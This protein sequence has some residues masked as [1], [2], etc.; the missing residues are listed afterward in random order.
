M[1]PLKQGGNEEDGKY[2]EQQ[3]DTL[4]AMYPGHAL[5][6][7]EEE[8]SIRCL[9]GLILH[10][11]PN[12]S[13]QIGFGFLPDPDVVYQR[14]NRRLDCLDVDTLRIPSGEHK[15]M[16]KNNMMY[17]LHFRKPS[18]LYTPEKE[19][20]PQT[21]VDDHTW[22]SPPGWATE[23][24]FGVGGSMSGGGG[25]GAVSTEKTK[26]ITIPFGSATGTYKIREPTA[27]VVQKW[28]NGKFS[29]DE[30]NLL[31]EQQLKYP[32][33]IYGLLLKAL[34]SGK[35]DDDSKTG[36]SPECKVYQFIM[37]DVYYNKLKARNA[38]MLGDGSN[39]GNTG[40]KT[41][42]STLQQLLE[43]LRADFGQLAELITSTTCVPDDMKIKFIQRIL[44]LN[45]GSSK[46]SEPSE[47]SDLPEPSEPTKLPKEEIKG[48]QK[49]ARDLLEKL[50]KYLK[51]KGG[52]ID[53]E[54]ETM[55]GGANEPITAEELH[56]IKE[57][58]DDFEDIKEY[59]EADID[60]LNKE[61]K[62][63]EKII[64][65]KKTDKLFEL[66]R[67]YY[68][69]VPFV[70]DIKL[71]NDEKIK[72]I[73]DNIYT[74]MINDKDRM[75]VSRLINNDDEDINHYLKELL[76]FLNKIENEFWKVTCTTDLCKEI[77]ELQRISNESLSTLIN[78]QIK[79]RDATI[80]GVSDTEFDELKQTVDNNKVAYHDYA[81][82][83]LEKY[84]PYYIAQQQHKITSSIFGVKKSDMTLRRDTNGE[85]I[86]KDVYIRQTDKILELKYFI[87]AL[88]PF[89]DN[90]ISAENYAKIFNEPADPGAADPGAAPL[91]GYAPLLIPIPT[92]Q[93]DFNKQITLLTKE[94][95]VEVDGIIKPIKNKYKLYERRF[96]AILC[97]TDICR[98]FSES[99]KEYDTI[100]KKMQKAN[101]DIRD[102][103]I[104]SNNLDKIPIYNQTVATSLAEAREK[105]LTLHDEY[106]VYQGKKE[107]RSIFKAPAQPPPQPPAPAQP[108]PQPPAPAQPIPQPPTQ[109]PPR[110]G[111]TAPL[112]PPAPRGGGRTRRKG[113]K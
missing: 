37:A 77:K 43:K 24:S 109:P 53:L 86:N 75:D 82:Q 78:S 94:Q 27:D 72:D 40:N 25:S 18:T 14:S 3:I 113:R 36:M 97:T 96:G 73:I 19:P 80:D 108:P 1:G 13:K 5:C 35:C 102:A 79:V 101:K 54:D 8:G 66:L 99:K 90:V 106:I 17:R 51:I 33:K 71:K 22:S 65:T 9:D 98:Q 74:T 84:E 31:S 100:M 50:R 69:I 59:T 104:N 34:Q 16:G 103:V 41:N 62:N 58:L 111:L 12:T 81:D 57:Y 95:V 105:A 76:P 89:E 23:I 87:Y 7:S 70:K 29:P 32:N 91:V 55:E 52:S 107:A 44:N 48:L 64:Y 61:L 67:V 85:L 47:P 42:T 110:D 68:K 6:L 30:E 63:M 2:I 56:R 38:E 93:E 60:K 88:S 21:L 83:V 39:T 15:Q 46:P 45:S 92:I 4:S 28:E 11:V 112:P 10:A 26:N 20:K 49:N